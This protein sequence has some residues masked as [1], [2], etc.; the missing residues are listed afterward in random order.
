MAAKH[1]QL[2]LDELRHAHGQCVLEGR[3]AAEDVWRV[4]Q[5]KVQQ[6]Q[7]KRAWQGG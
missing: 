7:H 3:Q 2:C 4:G 1:L 6:F 5:H